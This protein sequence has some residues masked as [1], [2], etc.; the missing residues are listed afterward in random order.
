MSASDL[1]LGIERDHVIAFWG[2]RAGP[3]VVFAVQFS[4]HEEVALLLEVKVTVSTHET[5]WV[6][7]LVAGLHHST[8]VGKEGRSNEDK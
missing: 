8:P 7:V 3:G 6:A 4:L 1:S 2:P 5:F